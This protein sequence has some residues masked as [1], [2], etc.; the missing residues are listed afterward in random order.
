MGTIKG[1]LIVCCDGTN[2]DGINQDGPLTNV[3]RITRCV[4]YEDSKTK[5]IPIVYYRSGV[6]TGTSRLGNYPDMVFGNGD[7]ISHNRATQDDELILIGFS[8]GAFEVRILALFISQVG[9][10]SKCGL[11]YLREVFQQWAKGQSVSAMLEMRLKMLEAEGLLDRTVLIKACAVWDTVAALPGNKLRFV[12]EQAPPNVEV[13]IQAL[14]LNEQRSQF[15]P[16]VWRK[17]VTPGPQ[18]ADRNIKQ[19]WFLGTHSDVGGGSREDASLSNIALAW[20]I[21][22]EGRLRTKLS[23]VGDNGHAKV[24]MIV[25]LRKLQA[26]NDFQ[27]GAF[28]KVQRISGWSNRAPAFETISSSNPTTTFEKLHW[29][30]NILLQKGLVSGCSIPLPQ[31]AVD[32]PPETFEQQLLTTWVGR[33]CLLGLQHLARQAR[34]R[35]GLKLPIYAVLQDPENWN[36]IES[37]D[38]LV[39]IGVGEMHS[40]EMTFSHGSNADDSSVTVPGTEIEVGESAS[41][42]LG[43]QYRHVSPWT[44]TE[45]G[46]GSSR[47]KISLNSRKCMS[48]TVVIPFASARDM[49]AGEDRLPPILA[50]LDDRDETQQSQRLS[51]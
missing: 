49:A 39:A 43:R 51:R 19:C 45:V 14:A 6:G 33:D 15:T 20:T 17:A 35:G 38:T 36:I 16:L 34:N 44:S 42:S 47:M 48:G 5:T 25:P 50:S 12:G 10:L 41:H 29:S 8:P 1:R 28:A 18:T 22:E 4:K 2:N 13:A 3:S 31:D 32:F 11:R 37:Y 27:A 21:Y 30:V 24:S 26:Q 7:F 9:V 40:V 23:R 46:R